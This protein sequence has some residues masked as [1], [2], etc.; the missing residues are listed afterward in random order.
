MNYGFD[1]KVALV[2]GAGRGIG[3]GIA[4][5]LAQAGADQAAAQVQLT[6]DEIEVNAALSSLFWLAPVADAVHEDDLDGQAAEDRDVGDGGAARAHLGE[7]GV[8]RCVEEGHFAVILK[9][10]RVRTDVLRDSSGFTF[11][12]VGV[13]DAVK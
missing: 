8:T 11:C 4:L 13:T 12:N 2:T 1:G 9:R 7:G 10:N 3:Q 5:S 6:V